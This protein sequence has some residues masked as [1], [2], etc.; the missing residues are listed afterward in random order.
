MNGISSM[1][2]YF[3]AHSFPIFFLA[4]AS[5]VDAALAKIRPE[6]TVVDPAPSAPKPQEAA[7]ALEIESFSCCIREQIGNISSVKRFVAVLAATEGNIDPWTG[8]STILSILA[9]ILR[10][11]AIVHARL[12]RLAIFSQRHSPNFLPFV[13]S[14]SDFKIRSKRRRVQHPHTIQCHRI[15]VQLL[16]HWPL[17][18]CIAIFNIAVR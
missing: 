14:P 18:V 10:K 15:A 17:R 11:V 6:P 5:S 9:K 8:Y 2:T 12:C 3:T 1:S 4:V 13:K 16:L 7:F